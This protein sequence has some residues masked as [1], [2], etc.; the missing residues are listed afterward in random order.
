MAVS[1]LIRTCSI[2]GR[3]SECTPAEFIP[4]GEDSAK[5]K[6][7]TGTANIPIANAF[8]LYACDDCGVER[9]KTPVKTWI[10]AILGHLL[11]ILGIVVPIIQSGSR[12]SGGEMAM[13]VL[14]FG[15]TGWL[16]AL[17]AGSLLFN[18]T[19]FELPRG[20]AG[21]VLSQMVPVLGL[22]LLLANRE[23]INRCARAMTALPA[24]ADTHVRE[25][26][27]E[28]EAMS[29]MAASG[30]PM[31][32]EEKQRVETWKTE[33]AREEERNE[34]IR[35]EAQEKVN[36]SN[37][38]GAIIGIIFTVIIGLI[39]L[40]AY[41]SGR[42]YM[43]FFGID[44]SAGGFAALIGAFIVYDVISLVSALKKRG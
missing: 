9:G 14:G 37:M 13:A 3:E 1:R 40:N 7:Y 5:L 42:G 21:L 10:F 28:D 41:S 36:K 22:I 29:R 6:P 12:G 26:R 15:S 27:A 44:L 20:L 43:T 30:E 25:A 33:K 39:G 35:R 34:S 8:T 23:R 19:R 24:A 16:M 31:T 11:M 18:K 2:C 4:V 32:P 38:T 17:I